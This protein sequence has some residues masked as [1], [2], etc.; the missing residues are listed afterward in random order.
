[1]AER[2]FSCIKQV[3]RTVQIPLPATFISNEIAGITEILESWKRQYKKQLQ[4]VVVNYRNLSLSSPT[5]F[6]APNKPFVYYNVKATFDLFCPKLGDIVKGKI[7]RIS[8]EHIGCLIEETINATIHLS[9]DSPQDLSPFINID[10]EILFEISS[11]NYERKMIRV[12]GKIT[13]KCIQLMRDLFPSQACNSLVDNPEISNNTDEG[14]GTSNESA[15]DGVLNRNSD[16][17]KINSNDVN[18]KKPFSRDIKSKKQSSKRSKSDSESSSNDS[19]DISSSDEKPKKKY[20]VSKKSKSES[21]SKDSSDISSSDEKPKKKKK[22]YSDKTSQDMGDHLNI[23]S[24]SNVVSS[25]TLIENFS[26]FNQNGSLKVLK[27]EVSSD[28]DNTHDKKHK[29]KQRQDSSPSLVEESNNPILNGGVSDL[30]KSAINKIDK[31]SKKR[32]RE[33]E[34]SLIDT[35]ELSTADEMPKKKKKRKDKSVS[36]LEKE[37]KEALLNMPIDDISRAKLSNIVEIH[38]KKKKH[39]DKSIPAPVLENGNRNELVEDP[40]ENI[41]TILSLKRE[42]FSPVRTIDN[43]VPEIK[44]KKKNKDKKTKEKK[45]SK[46]KKGKVLGSGA[47][48]KKDRKSHKKGPKKNKLDGEQ[49]K[50]HKKSKS[51]KKDKSEKKKKKDNSKS[52]KVSDNIKSEI[53]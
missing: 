8:K 24:L 14:I 36:L 1:M 19:S 43:I 21:S 5:G 53:D 52:K 42:I 17:S 40:D 6:I 41:A 38:K 2:E 34:S 32:K 49:S 13:P 37:I 35:S 4:G 46:K 15:D 22:K 48:L 31:L 39:K 33:S 29:K 47:V 7:N 23:N 20:K 44:D 9:K 51:H 26:N 18:F 30:D 50:K 27:E 11:F 45:R 25:D 3:V 10:Q 12:T 28:E 16:E